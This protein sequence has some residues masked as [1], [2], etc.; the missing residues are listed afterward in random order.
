MASFQNLLKKIV[1]IY[2]LLP[3]AVHVFSTIICPPFTFGAYFQS[4]TT[5]FYGNKII[6]FLECLCVN[7]FDKK[8]KFPPSFSGFFRKRIRGRLK[9]M[10]ATPGC[11]EELSFC[12][13]A[14]TQK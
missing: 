1:K 6:F 10:P 3:P 2:K 8:E 14:I 5:L 4:T 9:S 13:T 12:V 7:H 11:Q